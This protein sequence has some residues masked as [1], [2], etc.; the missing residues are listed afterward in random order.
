LSLANLLGDLEKSATSA[1][2]IK[3]CHPPVKCKI[4]HKQPALFI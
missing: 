3:Y 1:G 2:T 4:G